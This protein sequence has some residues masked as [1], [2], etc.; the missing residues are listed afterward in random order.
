MT[1]SGYTDCAC[2]DCFDVA[3]DGGLCSDCEKA[4]CEAHAETECCRDDAYGV[5]EEN[6]A[7]ITLPATVL[8]ALGWTCRTYDARYRGMGRTNVYTHPNYPRHEVHIHLS[9]VGALTSRWTHMESHPP[10]SYPGVASGYTI[11]VSGDETTIT[12]HFSD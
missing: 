1:T 10:Q 5:S 11:L 9:S 12:E 4:G 3:F 7:M 6:D 2:R 8:E